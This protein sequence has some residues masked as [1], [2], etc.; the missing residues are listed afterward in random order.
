MTVEAVVASSELWRSAERTFLLSVIVPVYQTRP[1]VLAALNSLVPHDAQAIEVIVVHDGGTDGALDLV[2]DWV[3]RAEVAALLLDQ[4]NAGLSAAR[5]TGLRYARGKVIGFL[6]SDDIV[7]AEVLL[8]LAQDAEERDCDVVLARSAV[9]DD[10]TFSSSP[11][12]DSQLWDELMDGAPFRRVTLAQ[13]PRLLRLEP[14]AN[15]RVLRRAFLDRSG[16]EFPIGRLYEDPPAHVRGLVHASA[17]GLRSETLYLYRVNRGGKITDERSS[18][19][20]DAIA[21]NRDALRVAS[22]GH[23]RTEAGTNLLIAAARML[24]W[25]CQNVVNE[26]RRRFAAEAVEV[27]REAPPVWRDRALVGSALGLREQL[28]LGAFLH[29]DPAV[30]AAF[31]ARQRPTLLATLRF[32]STRFGQPARQVLRN[33]ARERLR[34]PVQ[35]VRLLMRRVLA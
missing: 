25:C 11:F 21:T 26:D 5:M 19:R 31:A 29:G 20:F 6:D 34:W 33:L 15:T 32:A 1:Y 22:A 27:F 18:R 13:E 17:I 10:T 35:G 7:D 16:I 24:F 12:Y 9:L 14:N 2:Q 8:A 28:I 30:I 23:V 3:K 4:P